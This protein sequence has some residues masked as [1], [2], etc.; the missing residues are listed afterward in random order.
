MLTLGSISL[1][2]LGCGN[3]ESESGSTIPENTSQKVLT[4]TTPD[5]SEAIE[6]RIEGKPEDAVRILRKLNDEHPNSQEIL[7]Q[8]GRSLFDSQQFALAAFRL[9]QAISVGAETA[10]FKEA[11]EAHLKAGDEQS[12]EGLL[13]KYLVSY[14]DDGPASLNLCLLYTSPS[15]RG[16]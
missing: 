9:D 5:L 13:Q 8:L 7:L 6:K 14:P 15:P 11:A 12:A 4:R 16:A 2:I 3:Q 1:A 10:V